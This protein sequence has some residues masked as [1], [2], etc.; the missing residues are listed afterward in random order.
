MRTWRIESD[1]MTNDEARMSNEIRSTNAKD[2]VGQKRFDLEDRTA[3]FGE[4]IVAFAKKIPVTEVTRP[5][6]GQLVRAGTSVGSNYCEADDAGSKKEFR[7]RI[8]VCKREARETKYWLRLVAV[9]VP[10]LKDEARVSWQEARELHLIFA[11][12]VRGKPTRPSKTDT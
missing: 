9:A 7:Y 2:K 3:R 10:T 11:A 8:S 5:L 1:E 12:I 6:V 4:A